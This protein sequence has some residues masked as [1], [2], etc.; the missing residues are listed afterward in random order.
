MPMRSK[1]Q[2]AYLHIHLPELAARWEKLTRKGA[3]LPGH[4]K[5]KTKK[6]RK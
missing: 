5:T 1:A 6:R 4:V 2:R 3:K